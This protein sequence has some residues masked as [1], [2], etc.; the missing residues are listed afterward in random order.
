[1]GFEKVM[2]PK[3]QWRQKLLELRKQLKSQQIEGASERIAAK[4]FSLEEVR[5][6]DRLG[7]YAA[8]QNEVQTEK[9]FLQAH[10]LRKEIYFPAVDPETKNLQLY[11]VRHWSEL[12]K[13]F[14]GIL[15]PGS[16]RH[17][18]RN[19]NYLNVIV[20]PGVGFDRKGNR[21]GFGQGYYDRLLASYR[22]LKIAL[23]YD[24]QVLETLP[25]TP[26]DQRLD[27]ILTEERII[28]ATP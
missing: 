17:P 5:L 23:A 19:I 9:F 24:F 21:I 25:A 8:F 26:R 6:A 28:K 4:F 7:L 2:D 27:L 13:G 14:A 1:M 22:G 10:A 3:T 18:L 16:R 11:R 15:E 20:V 12:K